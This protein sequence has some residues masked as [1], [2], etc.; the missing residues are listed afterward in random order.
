MKYTEYRLNGDVYY[1]RYNGSAMFDLFDKFGE[2]FQKEILKSDKA[3]FNALC[4]ALPILSEQG[5]LSRRKEG[6]DKGKILT[7]EDC[8]TLIGVLDIAP[9]RGAFM[10]CLLAGL[11]QD[12]DP[13]A[14]VD[15]VLQ[16]IEKKT[17]DE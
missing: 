12:D 5:E 14:V 6:Y 11:R 3:G 17:E 9:A 13:D 16:E 15:E 7:A 2:D 4:E 8:K 1:L 10:E